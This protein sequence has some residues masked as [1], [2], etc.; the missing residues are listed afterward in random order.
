MIAQPAQPPPFRLTLAR[1]LALELVPHRPLLMGVVNV[2]PDSFSDGGRFLAPEHAVEHAL[3]LV[4]EGAALIDV[5]AESTRPRGATYGTGASAVETEE[6]L[7]RLLPVLDSLRRQSAIPI[8]ID[9]RKAAVAQAALDAGADLLNDVSGLEDPATAAVA[10]GAGCPVVL[11]HHRGIFSADPLPQAGE[12][13][14]EEVRAGLAAA[15]ARAFAAGCRREQLVLD[16][17]LGFGKAGRQNLEL[18]R[19]LGDLRGLA[20]LGRPLLVGASRKSF[21]GEASGERAPADR[22]P[23]SLAAAAWA[24]AGGASILRVHD[25]AATRRFLAT[26]RAI[27]EQPQD[28]EAD[29]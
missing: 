1:G 4:D 20:G 3:R 2:T 13:I 22:L 10:A 19:R 27:A 15:L 24:T 6:E 5:G 14:V 29:R 9:T 28:T 21:L 23:E 16:P 11:M 26:W 7:A 25:V 8:S 17:G 12:R 18:L